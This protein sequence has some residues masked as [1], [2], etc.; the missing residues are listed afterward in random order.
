MALTE[1]IIQQVVEDALTK[2]KDELGKEVLSG[3]VEGGIVLKAVRLT[4]SDSQYPSVVTMIGI[5]THHD[6]VDRLQKTFET[7]K[8]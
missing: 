1:S 2:F 6:V 4:P 8:G 3:K 7:W 5:S